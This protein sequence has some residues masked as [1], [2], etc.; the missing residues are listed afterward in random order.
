[1]FVLCLLLLKF[2]HLLMMR[3]V[4]RQDYSKPVQ[5]HYK[6]KSELSLKAKYTTEDTGRTH[7][8]KLNKKP[9]K[10]APFEKTDEYADV[11]DENWVEPRDRSMDEK[12]KNILMKE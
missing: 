8:E 3:I 7:G 10:S 5:I 11:H 1:M 4:W 2:A 12:S 9:S 6:I